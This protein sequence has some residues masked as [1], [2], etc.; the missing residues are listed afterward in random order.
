M[1][2]DILGLLEDA[3]EVGSTYLDAA[4]KRTQVLEDLEKQIS[5]QKNLT[6]ILEAIHEDIFG[7]W[8]EDQLE[9]DI[10]RYLNYRNELKGD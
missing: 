6:E 1:A 8:S 3:R 9:H 5:T 4:A 7:S 10:Q 2:R